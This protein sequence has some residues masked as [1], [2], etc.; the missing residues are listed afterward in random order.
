M[1]KKNLSELT[2]IQLRRRK[3]T[4]T[5]LIAILISASVLHLGLLFFDI[6]RGDG[7]E[8][9]LAAPAGM[10]VILAIIMSQGLKKINTE[11]AE[12]KQS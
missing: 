5:M 8:T 2:S 11:L 1:A 3:R 9:Y 6:I 10:C 4:S 7:T 12:R